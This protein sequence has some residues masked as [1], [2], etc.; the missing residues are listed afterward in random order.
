MCKTAKVGERNTNVSRLSPT[1]ALLSGP[2]FFVSATGTAK[3][4]SQCG[5]RSCTCGR[6]ALRLVGSAL[7][8]MWLWR[9]V[10][11]LGLVLIEIVVCVAGPQGLAGLQGSQLTGE[12]S[13]E[14]ISSSE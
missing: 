5:N 2:L 1:H 9:G 14:A 13:Q 3:Q 11:R 6:Y 12:W 7:W 10:S 4:S 8:L